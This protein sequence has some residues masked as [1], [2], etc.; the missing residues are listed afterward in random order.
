MAIPTDPPNELTPS[1]DDPRTM[2]QPAV[3]PSSPDLSSLQ[4][5][6][7]RT[8][9]ELARVQIESESEL[10][11]SNARRIELESRL[12]QQSDLRA[13]LDQSL[14]EA[15]RLK[16]SLESRLDGDQNLHQQVQDLRA[17]KAK[18][19][20]LLRDKETES[21]D[22][23]AE[24]QSKSEQLSAAKNTIRE[25]EAELLATRSSERTIRLQA[26]ASKSEAT[27]ACSDRDF[28][29]KELERTREEWQNFRSESHQ[30]TAR[31]QNDLD[32]LNHTHQ[33]LTVNLTTLRSQ[34]A[35]LQKLYDDATERIKQ[36][37]NQ[38]IEAEA[39][40]QKEIEAQKRVTQLMDQRD[41][42]REERMERFEREFNQRRVELEAR[43][44]LIN[45]ELDRERAHSAELQ[46][47]LTDTNHALSRLCASEFG[48]H[49]T[50]T[51]VDIT[52]NTPS[53]HRTP[54]TP[55]TRRQN[56]MPFSNGLSPAAAMA[57]KLQKNGKSL[58]E[59]YT[60][61]IALEEDLK[62]VRREN[63][64]LSETMSQILGE[65]QD[66]APLLHQQR[67]EHE[68]LEHECA[69]LTSQLTQVIEEKEEAQRMYQ[70]C[71]LDL[72]ALQRDYDLANSQVNDLSLQIRLLAVEVTQRDSGHSLKGDQGDLE[73]DLT[74]RPNPPLLDEEDHFLANDLV[75]FRDIADLQHK[76]LKL[77]L[78]A[79]TLSAKLNEME[80]TQTHHHGD[81]VEDDEDTKK[82]I[83]E[84]HELILK[85]KS[86]LQ[87]AQQKSE[88]LLRERDMLRR[89]FEQSKSSLEHPLPVESIV[90]DESRQKLEE[91]QT[92][93]EVYRAEIGRDSKQM[94]D[95]LNQARA[96][97]SR[98]QVLLAKANA[99]IEY[100]NERQRSL[101]QTNTLRV[102]EVQALTTS[103][104]KL[105]EHISRS[106]MLLHQANE[107]LTELKAKAR[108]LQHQVETL[109]TEREVWKGVE[110]RLQAENTS[111]ARERN[112]INDIMRNMQVMQGEIERNAEDSRRRL[113]GQLSKVEAQ[114]AEMKER[115]KVEADSARQATLQREI[116]SR[117]YQSKIDK[118]TGEHLAARENLSAASA[119]KSHLENQVL[120]LQK[121]LTLKGE[122]LA[123][124][125]GHRRSDNLSD[126]ALGGAAARNHDPTLSKE[127]R[128]EIEVSELKIELAAAKEECSRAQQH[129]EQFKSISESAEAALE[130]L[131]KTHDEYKSS[132]EAELERKQSTLAS[133]EEHLRKV[134]ED[135]ST[136]TTQNSE[137]HRQLESQRAEFEKEKLLLSNKL[138]DLEE[139]EARVKARD[140]ELRAEV[141]N[142]MKLAQD[143]HDRYQAEVQNHA[144]SLNEL[145]QV[146]S[147]LETARE[148]ILEF[149]S[150]AQT[151]TSKL[152]SSEASWAEQRATFQKELANIQ[153]RCDDLI[154]QN[155]LLHEHLETVSAQAT[156]LSNQ[157]I[158]QLAG[159]NSTEQKVFQ[160]DTNENIVESVEQLRGVIRYLRNNY[161]IAQQQIELSKMEST[162]L[163]Q[164]L[165]H[166]TK[167]LDQ[168][169]LELNHERERSRQGY[170]SSAEHA[171]LLDQI[172]T[173]NMIRESNITLRDEANRSER[174]AKQ[175]EERLKQTNDTLE[176]LRQELR[177]L[178]LTVQQYQQEISILTE[179][180]ER[181]KTRNQ[182]ILEKYDRIDPAEV[183]GL[184]DE[185]D[186]L[187]QEVTQSQEEI[188]QHKHF[189][190]KFYA[191]QVQ[192]RSI[193]QKFADEKLALE[194]K[195]NAG[196]EE[197]QKVKEVVQ[198][199]ES[200][201]KTFQSQ[202]TAAVQQAAAQAQ[203]Q[204]E[205]LR[206]EKVIVETNLADALNFKSKAAEAQTTLDVFKKEL[207]QVKVSLQSRENDFAQLR[208]ENNGIT[209]TNKQLTEEL[210]KLRAAASQGQASV[211]SESDIE[212]E[213]AKR[214]EQKL[215]SMPNTIT[216]TGGISDQELQERLEKINQ[217]TALEK[218]EAV[219]R[220]IQETTERLTLELTRSHAEATKKLEAELISAKNTSSISEELVL[221]RVNS[222]ISEIRQ[223][224]Q[225]AA[226]AKEQALIKKYEAELTEAR[227]TQTQ[228]SSHPGSSGQSTTQ[229]SQEITKVAV[230]VAVKAK[231]AELNQAHK[232]AT[233]SVI[234]T[235]K[236]KVMAEMNSKHNVVQMQLKR[237][238][239]KN[240]ELVAKITELNAQ[241]N[242]LKQNQSSPATSN[243]TTSAP[244]PTAPLTATA[245]PFVPSLPSS[246]PE[247]A[248]VATAAAPS[249]TTPA[250]ALT[251]NSPAQA[252]QTPPPPA[253]NLNLPPKPS[254]PNPNSQAIRGMAAGRGGARVGGQITFGKPPP[255]EIRGNRV[256]MAN[257][258]GAGGG[259][260]NPRPSP[261]PPGQAGISLAQG[262]SGSLP[263]EGRM[264]EKTN[265][266]GSV[267]I[268][269]AAKKGGPGLI[270]GAAMKQATG[271]LAE[272]PTNTPT[273]PSSQPSGTGTPVTKTPAKS[274]ANN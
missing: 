129:V 174:K 143:N 44:R 68:R 62:K 272:N 1:S 105:Q 92:Q 263:L 15:Q 146:K 75:T 81:D 200:E 234:E 270:L 215:A 168:T 58:T 138:V 53:V 126:Q 130:S 90:P 70:G 116:E 117:D 157:S 82:A 255:R 229:Q 185:L 176:P 179:D 236:A 156:K 17:D 29:F 240:T 249:A 238:H 226:T 246:S 109:T 10:N 205:A 122:R 136:T 9:A 181:W 162:R 135:L 153:T 187:K 171:Q 21:S 94:S 159:K 8:K 13:Q 201:A 221:A 96:D 203:E 271:T 152:A 261:T 32:K 89:M 208:M 219:Q 194:A 243:A 100:L 148:S 142:Q 195:L 5:E 60:E 218:A 145:K 253:N 52:A 141:S 139:I 12:D 154:K 193:R 151:A 198:N 27:L 273:P 80:E 199:L 26:Q 48:E 85:L 103:N 125:E 51:L 155:N 202:M 115:V 71:L 227:Q 87:S 99:Q 112:N 119:S 214:L 173:L 189:R 266:A 120:Q 65:I 242:Q 101:D 93:F 137:L 124:Y 239:A 178:K 144:N 36:L 54:G 59:V 207:D 262:G 224:L 212:A 233:E 213:V 167:A 268:R 220:A 230:D 150:T 72:N 22:L 165:Q 256:G 42:Q 28:Y 209:S 47:K 182:Q 102:Q 31:L 104:T 83:D 257:W 45:E 251:L 55:L 4:A 3:T 231:E 114:L 76:N 164:Q 24:L 147:E 217:Q 274:R 132:Q 245:S 128:L 18:L 166:A 57:S 39:A 259:P 228:A 188:A 66:R 7:D 113:E 43:E 95:D 161:D 77:L 107:N 235:T 206:Q 169:K 172:N 19:L 211:T 244:P 25:L 84:A 252:S 88:A 248:Q 98:T 247:V 269:G 192:A 121:Q 127:Q 34:H 16:A 183:Q 38:S 177:E 258:N 41:K 163:Q 35:D 133:L 184:R 260:A 158:D 6:L 86:D 78:F 170:V 20:Q 267:M 191:I 225:A 110:G 134:T 61:R 232:V 196:N 222:K 49:E 216:S 79:R 237:S 63:V 250:A 14:Q 265:Q 33:S 180:N 123:V 23:E 69:E 50:N 210:V 111:L 223:E 74:N 140:N 11:A 46:Q 40:F 175:L 73:K 67:I 91:L 160:N 118:L 108:V 37:T 264:A 190:E 131:S 56:G 204:L 241:L 149:Q 64:R 106:E 97:L 30:E 2:P 254:D 197:L 186:R